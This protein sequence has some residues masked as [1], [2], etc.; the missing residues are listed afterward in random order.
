MTPE[1]IT[2]DLDTPVARC[3]SLL[4][5]G[6]IRHLPL[7]D[8][9]WLVGV[10]DAAVVDGADDHARAG[11]LDVRKVPSVP[12]DT[13]LPAVLEALQGTEADVVIVTD[14]GRPIGL[15][16]EHDAVRLAAR[17][18]PATLGLDAWLTPT[19]STIEASSPVAAARL[20]LSEEVNR[21]LVVTLQ[22]R[23]H[24]V[25]SWR[26][27]LNVAEGA[28]VAECVKPVQWRLATSSSLKEAAA[29][30]ARNHIGLLPIVTPDGRLCGVVSRTDVAAAL[31]EH[32][33]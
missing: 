16:T 27:L 9:G 13:P 4:G 14:G 1:P 21:H 5:D 33:D 3:R 30:M 24:A 28:Q 18:L 2:V 8:D 15:F 25:L 17:E 11:D 31:Y 26:D 10:V 19:V 22:G 6:R 20:R 23:L 12:V 7:L 29:T 32:L